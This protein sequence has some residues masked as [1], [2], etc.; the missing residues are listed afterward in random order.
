MVFERFGNSFLNFLHLL[1]KSKMITILIA[2]FLILLGMKFL[3]FLSFFQSL[4]ALELGL[5]PAESETMLKLLH[6]HQ[7]P[8]Y[9]ETG[10]SVLMI[11]EDKIDEA[12]KVLNPH[13]NK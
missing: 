3:I 11:E 5:E 13:S 4:K 6:Q 9:L 7:I 8:A 2:L 12:Q 10:G 1:S